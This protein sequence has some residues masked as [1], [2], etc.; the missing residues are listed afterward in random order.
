MKINRVIKLFTIALLVFSLFVGCTKDGNNGNISPV[1]NNAGNVTDTSNSGLTGTVPPVSNTYEPVNIEDSQAYSEIVV[2]SNTVTDTNQDMSDEDAR[3]LSIGLDEASIEEVKAR[4]S[5]KYC[6]S[7]MDSSLHDLYAEI[8]IILSMNASDIKI[9]TTDPEQLKYVFHCVFNDHPE[10]YWVNGYS[11]IIHELGG[12]TQY[13]TFSGKYIY[14]PEERAN[15]QVYIDAYVNNCLGGI[16]TIATDYDKVKYVYEY[17]IN[18]TQYVLNSRDN[19]NIISVF[20]FGESV[21]QG[22]A[23]AFQ[24]LMD[25]LGIPCTMVAGKVYTGEGHA[26]NLVNIGGSYYYVDPTWGDSSYV[27]DG[28]RVSSLDMPINYDFLNIT[29]DELTKTHIIDNV[30]PMP[31]CVATEYNYYVK[32]GL[33]FYGYDDEKLRM[34]FDNAYNSNQQLVTIKCANYEAYIN[35]YNELIANQRIFQYL[36]SGSE[37]VSYS[38][39]DNAYS[40]YFWI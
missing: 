25:R 20:M 12:V 35:I 5:S 37:T 38:N 4:Q 19:Q 39:D 34:A 8:Y 13:M 23:K 32:E 31:Q 36:K 33:L 10:I 26:W 21:C 30:V 28:G 1:L 29:T 16:S 24:Y 7:V 15:F 6:Y 22:Y 18:H 40:L 9:S 3:R 17:I 14:T 11:Y 2:E 27:L